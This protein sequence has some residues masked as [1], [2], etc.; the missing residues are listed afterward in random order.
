MGPLLMEDKKSRKTDLFTQNCNGFKK[1][2][3]KRFELNPLHSFAKGVNEKPTNGSRNFKL[4][5][6][7]Y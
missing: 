3:M 7:M 5:D 6:L 4:Y 2:G 1:L